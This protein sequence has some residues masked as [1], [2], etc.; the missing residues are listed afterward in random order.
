MYFNFYSISINNQ[1][2]DE[3]ASSGRKIKSASPNDSPSLTKA[4]SAEDETK[5]NAPF[6]EWIFPIP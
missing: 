1:N 4:I 2:V 5:V 3:N 6:S